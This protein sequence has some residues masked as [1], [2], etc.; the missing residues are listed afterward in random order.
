MNIV[1]EIIRALFLGGTKAS[2]EVTGKVADKW[3]SLWL[4]GVLP[5]IVALATMYYLKY[6]GSHAW[7]TAI[8]FVGIIAI[9]FI[10]GGP[11]LQG[12]SLILGGIFKDSPEES[13]VSSAEKVW[14]NYWKAIGYLLLWWSVIGAGIIVVPLEYASP[15][16]FCTFLVTLIA[17]EMME[18]YDWDLKDPVHPQRKKGKIF[19][20]HLG[21]YVL[22]GS[23]LLVM[24]FAINAWLFNGT[25]YRLIPKHSASVAENKANSSN[26]ELADQLKAKCVT[27]VQ[28]ERSNHAKTDEERLLT[29]ADF[30]KINGC[31]SRIDALVGAS[32]GTSVHPNVPPSIHSQ[33]GLW[34][35]F[36][37]YW[38]AYM[39]MKTTNPVFFWVSLIVGHIVLYKLLKALWSKLR[40]KTT[41]A[42]AVTVK[43]ATKSSGSGWF[44]LVGIFV[45]IL[46][47][48][49]W[50]GLKNP[51]HAD[52]PI[53]F[54]TAT[55]QVTKSAY[56]IEPGS[57]S[58]SDESLSIRIGEHAGR[59]PLNAL[60]DKLN[61]GWTQHV[62][63]VSGN[64]EYFVL[65]DVAGKM[66][67]DQ[68]E[69]DTYDCT[70]SYTIEG[71]AAGA[72]HLRFLR[73]GVRAI[74]LQPYD[75]AAPKTVLEMR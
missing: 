45:L 16:L 35:G 74:V 8:F 19:A 27:D 11:A 3:I 62:A 33:G 70:G 72:Y 36:M 12:L 23:F 7:P 25:G 50:I 31:K 41:V 73:D 63:L 57:Y 14:H 71:R 59:N 52:D 26:I 53:R 28:A 30:K 13:R 4:F 61:G 47:G 46:V 39:A 69:R 43:T 5:A 22:G 32:E 15:G 38:D 49:Y 42:S 55:D 2:R 17:H 67:A 66:C 48:L 1:I 58:F 37:W 44:R 60:V 68:K 64:R 10:S 21:G 20:W 40:N 54:F 34:G 6:A 29:S 65:R 56:V 18:M 75:S 24:I 9:L 51:S